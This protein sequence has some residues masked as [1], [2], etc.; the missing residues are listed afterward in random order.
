MV[1]IKPYYRVGRISA[2]SHDKSL[3]SMV[4]FKPYL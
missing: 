3:T 4:Y 2:F 1:T